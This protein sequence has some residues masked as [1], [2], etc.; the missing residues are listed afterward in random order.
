[1]SELLRVKSTGGAVDTS[2]LASI[3]GAYEDAAQAKATADADLVRLASAAAEHFGPIDRSLRVGKLEVTI[4][5]PKKRVVDPLVLRDLLGP[6]VSEGVLNGVV[7]PKPQSYQVVHRD[8]TKLRALD[9]D[10][11]TAA[12][13][14]ASEF[15]DQNRRLTIKAIKPTESQAA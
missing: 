9:D 4:N 12:I 14:L 10:D 11:I 5:A 2:D 15:E 6:L 8:L 3:V 1:M 7:R 13:E